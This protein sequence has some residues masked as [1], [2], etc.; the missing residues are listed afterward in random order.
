MGKLK[1]YG[2][3][4]NIL[5]WMGSALIVCSVLL[6]LYRLVISPKVQNG[7]TEFSEPSKPDFKVLLLTSY[8]P[9]HSSYG[10]Q[11]TGLKMGLYPNSISY[12]VICMDTKNYGKS[13]QVEDFYEFFKKRM[14]DRTKKYDGIITGDDAALS[15][16][17]KHQKEFFDGVPV[18]FFGINNLD[19]AKEGAENPWMTGFTEETYIDSTIDMASRLMPYATKVVAIYDETT[20]G[21]GDMKTFY[22]FEKDYPEYKFSGI[23]TTLYT[24]KEFEDIL[25][26][27]NSDT[28]LIYLTAF[29]DKDDNNY[30]IPQSVET[31]VSHTHIPVFRNYQT[32]L[33]QGI[34]GGVRMNFPEQCKMA[35]YIMNDVLRGKK[36]ISSIPL[37]TKTPGIVS[38]DY[39]LMKKFNL[40]MSKLPKDTVFYNKPVN[41]FAEFSRIGV[42]VLMI[43]GGLLLI[44]AGFVVNMV[45]LRNVGEKQKYDAEHD[46]LTELNNRQT[47]ETVLGN[48][49]KAG[50]AVSLIRLDMDNF[51]SVNVTYGHKVGDDFLRHI[52]SLLK[53]FAA[54]KNCFVARY[55]GDEFIV[56]SFGG[57][58]ERNGPLIQALHELF[59][60]P[61]EV[62]LEHVKTSTSIGIAN[63]TQDSTVENMFVQAGIAMATAKDRGKNTALV[64]SSDFEEKIRRQ[65][66]IRQEI[67]DAI[68]NDGFYMVYQPKVDARTKNL[69]GYEAL[70]RMKN[71]TIGP[72]EF[73]PVAE[74]SGLICRIGRIITEQTIR[75][76]ALWKDEGRNLVNVSINYSSNQV[77]DVGYV[78]FLIAT[79]GKYGVDS[80]LIG[81]EITES[82]FMENTWQAGVLFEKFKS[83]GVEILMDDFGTGYSSLS[84]LTYIPV[85]ILKLD[86]SLVNAYLTDTKA[87]FIRDV[88]A[89]THDLGKKIVI[90]GV[91]E[92]W[93]YESLR[94]FGADVIQGY[95]FSRP[96]PA[97]DAIGWSAASD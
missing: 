32:G 83:L 19:L 44:L 77:S 29:N 61:M 95:Y 79:L 6:L 15:F 96:L 23:D 49:L 88:I 71:N 85:D 24:R 62:G 67:V 91:E 51:K 94:D 38:Y 25:E 69:V 39:L 86:K 84:Y 17:L 47:A 9:V 70:V 57:A 87:L 3:F 68:E 21:Q 13:D 65:N 90:E 42:P 64:F 72:A 58:L 14:E 10:R 48:A 27:L 80:S 97:D 12:D 53:K 41:Y 60:T 92:K 11:E 93:Q 20:T 43:I 35:G 16:A 8:S 66:R 55:S 74:Q 4:K 46:R 33:G 26:G 59:Q 63:S 1:V 7:A 40:D 82:L 30:T 2:L 89:L 34:L 28:I 45:I 22:S 54:Q 76:M 56:I 52:A 31:I 36:S 37:N 5:I 78:D 75:Q 18:V 81:L 73:I 50:R